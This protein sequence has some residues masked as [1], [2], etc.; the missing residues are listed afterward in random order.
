M[1]QFHFS[2]QSVHN[3][4]EMRRDKAERALAAALGELRGAQVQ[5]ETVLRRR[6][7]AM[8]NYLKVHQS[9]EIEAATFATHTDYIGSLFQLERHSRGTIL[10][11][12]EK[13][14]IKRL[15]LIEASRQTETTANLRDRQRERHYQEIAQHEQKMLD[16]MAVAGVARRL[17]NG[18]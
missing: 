4:R 5:L 12:E 16:E 13:I 7:S 10:Q 6:Q 15:A 1:K 9:A 14:A 8:E 11:L 17:A 3:F 2:L 18:Y